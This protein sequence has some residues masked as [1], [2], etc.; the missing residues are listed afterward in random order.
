MGRLMR[1]MAICVCIVVQYQAYTIHGLLEKLEDGSALR[2]RYRRARWF[3]SQKTRRAYGKRRFFGRLN[4]EFRARGIVL[5]VLLGLLLW[6]RDLY[7]VVDEGIIRRASRPA[8][9]YSVRELKGKTLSAILQCDGD[10]ARGKTKNGI[11]FIV[12]I[13][14]WR[15]I[16]H[17][18]HMRLADKGVLLD[19]R[20]KYTPAVSVLEQLEERND[21]VRGALA[22]LREAD[23]LVAW[24]LYDHTSQVE[25]LALS[26]LLADKVEKAQLVARGSVTAEGA[27]GKMVQIDTFIFGHVADPL[28]S[29]ST[30]GDATLAFLGEMTFE[31]RGPRVPSDVSSQ[32][33]DSSKKFANAAGGDVWLQPSHHGTSFRFTL[34][35]ELVSSVVQRGHGCFAG[36]LPRTMT[37]YVVDDSTLIR[38][39]IVAKLSSL[40]RRVDGEFTYHEHSTVESILPHLDSFAHN[41]N[42]VVTVDENLDSTGG[43]LRGADLITALVDV[44]FHGVIVSCSGDDA[45]T[46]DHLRRGADLSWGKPLPTADHM[47][48][49][50]CAA[51]NRKIRKNRPSMPRGAGVYASAPV[52]LPSS[53]FDD[54]L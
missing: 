21:D 48:Q 36:A 24:G 37:F 18:S 30:R 46:S 23:S 34:P 17:C 13:K 28:L 10:I 32:L 20:N 51:Y 35:G 50:L 42:V 4:A 1:V 44:S 52:T 5:F 15:R 8:F 12:R 49:S 27:D 9:G 41:A 43:R 7:F 6:R 53:S 40:R 38:R 14:R 33:L 45:V 47:L 3:L 31:V 19:L 54:D 26:D 29:I 16:L 22:L 25:V 2:A 39:A 11:D